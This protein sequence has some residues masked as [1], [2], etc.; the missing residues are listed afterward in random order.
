MSLDICKSLNEFFSE[1]FMKLLIPLKIK[2]NPSYFP[3]FPVVILVQKYSLLILKKQTVTPNH[4]SAKKSP[5]R[6]YQCLIK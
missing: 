4:I 2:I 5:C 3:D 1:Y 6:N